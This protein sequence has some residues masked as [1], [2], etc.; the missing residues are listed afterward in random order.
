MAQSKEYKNALNRIKYDIQK[1]GKI[2]VKFSKDI[3][4]LYETLAT[5]NIDDLLAFREDMW[6]GARLN[7]E[8][9]TSIGKESIKRRV[10]N[11]NKYRSEKVNTSRTHNQILNITSNNENI[12]NKNINN[13]VANEAATVL[14]NIKDVL[15]NYDVNVV[16][17]VSIREEKLIIHG[18]SLE[19]YERIINK[20]TI[21]YG[22]EQGRNIAVRIIN[23]SPKSII[24]EMTKALYDSTTSSTD[25]LAS[26]VYQWFYNV[27]EELEKSENG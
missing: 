21:L 11:Q 6:K 26:V 18:I 10:K 27:L 12:S 3:S 2:G 1:Y 16:Y 9:S 7:I 20:L 15:D 22:D 19:L 5:E 13:N 8:G 17:P 23:N 24:N 14:N 25:S 4:Q